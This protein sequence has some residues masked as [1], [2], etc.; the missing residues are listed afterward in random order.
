M[1]YVLYIVNYKWL[2]FTYVQNLKTDLKDGE[3]YRKNDQI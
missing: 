2:E 3:K 1:K